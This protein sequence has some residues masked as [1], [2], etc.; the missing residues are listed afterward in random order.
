VRS[1]GQFATGIRYENEHVFIYRFAGGQLFEAREFTDVSTCRRSAREGE[2][3]KA[4]GRGGRGR[5]LGRQ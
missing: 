2:V 3:A 5:Y 4:V 1:L